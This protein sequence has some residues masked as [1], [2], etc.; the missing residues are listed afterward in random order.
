MQA[1][2]AFKPLGVLSIATLWLAIIFMV[3]KWNND[4]TLSISK[5]SAA[6]RS[7]YIFML[8]VQSFVF[9]GY[10]L[11]AVKW[12]TPTF[13]LPQFFAQITILAFSLFFIA[14]W[15]PDTTGWKNKLHANAAYGAA[16]LLVPS[17]TML[18]LSPN[19]LGFAKS[20]VLFTLVY[21]LVVFTLFVANNKSSRNH[22]YFQAA[23][24]LLY[25]LSVLVVTY[26]R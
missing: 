8:V 13:D 24:F 12:L 15:A 22:L 23:Y 7:A 6:N 1:V 20:F 9:P 17:L 5:H 16:L 14:A 2:E 4:K 10:I 25:D 21:Q 3:A 18:Y 11:F 26:M 19:V